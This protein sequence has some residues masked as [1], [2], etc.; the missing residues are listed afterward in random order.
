M[1][2]F[3]L[4]LLCV[5]ALAI[6]CS[7][8]PPPANG[9]SVATSTKRYVLE[10]D[11]MIFVFDDGDDAEKPAAPFGAK[12]GARARLLVRF[13][14]LEATG[15]IER[16]WLILDRVQGAQAGP[17]DVTLRVDAIV[18]PWSIPGSAGTGWSTPP[19]SESIASA[20]VS[21]RGASPIR[22]DVTAWAQKLAKKGPRPW[23]L[24]VE[25][26]GEGYGVPIATG[27][28]NGQPPRLEVFVQ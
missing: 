11:A 18:E 16:A 17:G 25:G 6:G 8:T 19:K 24:R 28:G 21:A 9:V 26:S 1:R 27:A 2:R 10:P 14:H 13:P 5:M 12:V 7:A 4:G 15:S 20:V 23:G 22:V 3:A